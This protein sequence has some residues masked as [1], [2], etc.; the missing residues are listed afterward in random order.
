[1]SVDRKNQRDEPCVMLNVS[2][3]EDGKNQYRRLKYIGSDQRGRR[4]TKYIYCQGKE[5]SVGEQRLLTLNSV[6]KEMRTE[7]GEG[8]H[9]E[10][11]VNQ[12]KGFLESAIVGVGIQKAEYGK[13]QR[14]Y[15]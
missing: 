3:L 5:V 4:K 2:R 1:M 15:N 13:N 14:L 12:M 8:Q 6:R 11:W 7:W 9:K 10:V